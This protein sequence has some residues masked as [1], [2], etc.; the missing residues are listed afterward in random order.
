MELHGRSPGH[1][2]SRWSRGGDSNQPVSTNWANY[3]GHSTA[4][5]S[6]DSINSD[7]SR[8]SNISSNSISSSSN[9]D[10]SRDA[11]INNLSSINGNGFAQLH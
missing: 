9:R 1:V 10:R 5:R 4:N 7:T 11:H 8:S 3:S 6:A 2:I